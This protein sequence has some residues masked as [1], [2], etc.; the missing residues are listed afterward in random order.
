MSHLPSP[1]IEMVR[2]L[3][4]DAMRIDPKNPA[5]SRPRPLH[6]HQGH[7]CLALYVLLAVAGSFLC[8]VGATAHAGRQRETDADRQPMPER[9]G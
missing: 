4:D 7:G 9:S 6:P 3:Y 8:P 5:R 1:L 2:V